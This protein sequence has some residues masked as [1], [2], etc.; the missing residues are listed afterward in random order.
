[1]TPDKEREAAQALKEEDLSDALRLRN[2]LLC[3]VIVCA[4]AAVVLLLSSWPF[5]SF[6]A[7]MLALILGVFLFDSIGQVQQIRQRPYHSLFVRIPPG[8]WSGGS[9]AMQVPAL[10]KVGPA[11]ERIE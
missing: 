3:G 2:R 8:P 1:M 4:A 10:P 6:A 9:T 11:S 7:C 5:G